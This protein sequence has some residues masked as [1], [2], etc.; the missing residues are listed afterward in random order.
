MLCTQASEVQ[1]AAAAA[2]R[3][4]PVEAAEQDVYKEQLNDKAVFVHV[5]V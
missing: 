1:L 3:H 5:Y 2:G 4:V